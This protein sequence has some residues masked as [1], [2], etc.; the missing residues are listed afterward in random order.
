MLRSVI[1]IIIY[2]YIAPIALDLWTLVLYFHNVL[3][4]QTL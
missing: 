1:K 4:I 2:T 3:N